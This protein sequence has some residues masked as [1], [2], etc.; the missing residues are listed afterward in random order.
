VAGF[1]QAD[2]IEGENTPGPRARAH[3]LK[4]AHLEF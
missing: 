1:A 4:I 2:A 3:D